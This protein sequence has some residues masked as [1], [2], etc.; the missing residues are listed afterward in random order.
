M[1]L[2]NQRNRFNARE[3]MHS[4]I[5]SAIVIVEN[6]ADVINNLGS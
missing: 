4:L 6:Y 5:A 2:R 3:N 1:V